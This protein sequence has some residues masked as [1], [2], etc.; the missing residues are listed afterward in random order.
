MNYASVCLDVCDES[1]S[2]TFQK[3]SEPFNRIYSIAMKYVYVF[4]RFELAEL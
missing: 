3:L 1:A 4:A 2:H